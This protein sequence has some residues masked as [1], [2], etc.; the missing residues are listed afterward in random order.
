LPRARSASVL[1]LP[2]HNEGVVAKQA[3]TIDV[4]SEG[5]FSLGVGLGGRP[6]DYDVSPASWKGRAARFEQQLVT[7]RRIWRGEA[8]REGTL[9]I[10]PTP[11]TPGGP[12]L[13]IGAFAPVGLQ[14]AGRLADGIR[15][16]GFTPD[17]QDHR[18]RF[19]I[20][21]QAWKEAGRDGRPK[22]ICSM[23]FALGP[24]AAEA[25]ENHIRTYY[26]YDPAL[27]ERAT[28]DRPPISAEVISNILTRYAAADVDHVV[29]TALTSD[30][31]GVS[32]DHLAAVVAEWKA[33]AAST[34]SS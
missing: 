17:L 24:G 21:A 12:E 2:M 9:P 26:S 20:T 30:T 25:Y 8:P 31:S 28:R 3:A 16:F 29:F 18:D 10:G 32:I 4:L 33:A 7:L 23:N 22:L 34:S 15:S 14:R 27:V 11:F 5:R 19:A 6:Q 13:I 1:C